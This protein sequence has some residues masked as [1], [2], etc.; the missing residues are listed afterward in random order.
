MHSWRHPPH[1]CLACCTYLFCCC[2]F[3]SD[4]QEP[5]PERL[6]FRIAYRYARISRSPLVV[7]PV[8]ITTARD[9]T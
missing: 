6:I 1:I 5:A 8:A 3:L 2:D 7:I 9:T 4:V